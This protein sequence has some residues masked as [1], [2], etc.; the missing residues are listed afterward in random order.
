MSNFLPERDQINPRWF[1]VWGETFGAPELATQMSGNDRIFIR[2]RERMFSALGID[3][4]A[5]QNADD[6]VSATAYS[7]DKSR[8]TRICGMVMHGE[9]LRGKIQ[10]SD[11]ELI[12]K[13]FSFED[14]KI[15]VSLRHLHPDSSEFG[16]DMSRLSTL[17]EGAGLACIEAW[18]A[19][20]DEQMG[21]RIH[22]IETDEDL[23]KEITQSVNAELAYEIVT[24]VS[25]KLNQAQILQAA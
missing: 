24:E 7:N 23:E 18:K 5:Q 22:L 21:M 6:I 14:L 4:T 19:G 16:S 8:L 15:A 10:K 25:K 17:I 1:T 20:L 12:A 13:I 9:F 11:F 3:M 2:A